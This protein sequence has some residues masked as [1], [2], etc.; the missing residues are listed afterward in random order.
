MV[1]AFA[2]QF[3]AKVLIE[4]KSAFKKVV[5]R[6]SGIYLLTKRKRVYYVGLASKL[7]S[8]LARHLL[9]RHDGKWDGFSFYS[10]GK[11]RYLKDIETIL[12]RVL[13]PSGNA[14]GGNFGRRKNLNHKIESE[15]LAEVKKSLRAK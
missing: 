12:I 4:H 2:E 3:S 9:D 8:R 13:K 14:V 10:I 6:K 7:S 15:I 5:G 1:K 11:K